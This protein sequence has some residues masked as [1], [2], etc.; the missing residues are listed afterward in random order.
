[1]EFLDAII[2]LSVDSYVEGSRVKVSARLHATLFLF[3]LQFILGGRCTE[4]FLVRVLH[5]KPGKIFG[6]WTDQRW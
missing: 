4:L 2:P 3:C 5:D 6:F 1:M